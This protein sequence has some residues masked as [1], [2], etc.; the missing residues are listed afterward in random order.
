MR[1]EVQKNEDEVKSI[2]WRAEGLQGCNG[3]KEKKMIV[4]R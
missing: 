1:Q 2:G 4:E 3:K